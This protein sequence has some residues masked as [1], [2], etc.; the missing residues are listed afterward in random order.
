MVAYAAK[1]LWE[2]VSKD[3]RE[4]ARRKK[5]SEG[6]GSTSHMHNTYLSASIGSTRPI[7]CRKC[8]RRDRTAAFAVV[9]AVEPVTARNISFS[10]RNVDSEGVLI[11]RP[12]SGARYRY[13]LF[14]RHVSA[15]AAKW[16]MWTHAII[17]LAE[18]T[19]DISVKR[20]EKSPRCTWISFFPPG[21]G[22]LPER[23]IGLISNEIS[24]DRNFA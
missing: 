8:C 24:S 17:S 6:H 20:F 3:K 22:S 4:A 19:S 2:R 10:L 18:L 13:R 7:L 5:S 9:V 15:H 14:P 23:R 12:S 11:Q 1:P 16:P 21:V